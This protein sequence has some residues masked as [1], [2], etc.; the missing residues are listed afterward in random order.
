MSDDS[1]TG[2]NAKVGFSCNNGNSLIG[3]GEIKCLASGRWS[4][5]IPACQN[6]VCSQSITK[7]TNRPNLRAYVH[8]FGAG[9]K[10]VLLTTVTVALFFGRNQMIAI[11]ICLFVAGEAEFDC[12]RGHRLVGLKKATCLNNGEWS[13]ALT[14]KEEKAKNNLK[15]RLPEC[16]AITC[17]KP[18][19]P[20]NGGVSADGECTVLL[21][22]IIFKYIIL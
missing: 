6:V 16:M 5:P 8:S 20:E 18:S 3:A 2:L 13:V 22:L 15:G 17:S 1:L 9:G 21:M 7:L 14:A 10:V 19:A 11:S 12:G 4:A